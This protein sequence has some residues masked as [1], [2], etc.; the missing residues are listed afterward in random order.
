MARDTRKLHV[1]CGF[2]QMVKSISLVE[3]AARRAGLG[4]KRRE[5]LEAATREAYLA[6]VKAGPSLGT[7]G[8]IDVDVTWSREAIIVTLFHGG[9]GLGD[10]FD[11]IP[12]DPRVEAMRASVDEV[13]YVQ[14]ARHGNQ[15]SLLLR[16]LPSEAR[17]TAGARAA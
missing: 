1:R 6:I 8:P 4:P 9:S 2:D 12:L 10:L 5:G 3:E 7:K 16:V 17:K 11:R 15:L 13:R 14:G